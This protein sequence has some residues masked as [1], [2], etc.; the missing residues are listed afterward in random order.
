MLIHYSGRAQD[1]ETLDALDAKW[2]GER[3]GTTAGA[4][5]RRSCSQKTVDHWSDRDGRKREGRCRGYHD[6][7]RG[8]FDGTLRRDEEMFCGVIRF[9]GR[10][11]DGRGRLRFFKY[12]VDYPIGGG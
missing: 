4:V 7:V 9:L 3:D 10:C 11:W 6:G 2:D 5:R 8:T 12:E 1:V